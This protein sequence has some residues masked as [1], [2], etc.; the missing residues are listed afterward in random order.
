MTVLT[1]Q[2]ANNEN[3]GQNNEGISNKEDSE[4]LV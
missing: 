4:K 1:L 2:G 3:T